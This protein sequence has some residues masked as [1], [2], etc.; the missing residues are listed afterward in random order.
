MKTMQ[1]SQRLFLA[2]GG[3]AGAGGV[4]A[5]AA[6]AHGGDQ[7]L[8]SAVALVALTHAALLV[9]LALAGRGMI[10]TIASALIA[11]GLVLFCGDLTLS[12][13]RGVGLFTNA[14]P[15]GGMILIGGWLVIVMAAVLPTSR[16]EL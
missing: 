3:L 8:M 10:L 1:L 6:S 13:T 4:A 5:A 14:A 15:T 7:R 11:L 9:A 2:L 16:R 12:A